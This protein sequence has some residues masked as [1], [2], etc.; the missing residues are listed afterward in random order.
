MGEELPRGTVQDSPD[1]GR[2][3]RPKTACRSAKGPSPVDTVVAEAQ[4]AGLG[5]VREPVRTGPDVDGPVEGAGSSVHDRHRVPEA[6]GGPQVAS[7][8]ESCS[9]SGLPPTCH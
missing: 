6:V 1:G 8:G 3:A 5:E 2:G 4:A 7:I 9:M